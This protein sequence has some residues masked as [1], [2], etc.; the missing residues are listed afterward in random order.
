[1]TDEPGIDHP[2]PDADPQTHS[3]RELLARGARL[4]GAAAVASSGLA[5]VAQTAAGQTTAR[6][7]VRSR[8]RAVAGGVL[9]VA[10]PGEPTTLDPHRSTLDVFR[11]SVR[12]AVWRASTRWPPA[13]PPDVVM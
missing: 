12:S 3:R 5:A 7:A 13:S 11:H 4:A 10:E 8:A 2:D 1:M 6:A 9:T